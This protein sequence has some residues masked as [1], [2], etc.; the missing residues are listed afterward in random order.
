MKNKIL[1]ILILFSLLFIA[2]ISFSLQIHLKDKI[3]TD[4]ENIFLK[5]IA[6]IVAE[7]EV[8][9]EKY[10]DIYICRITQKTTILT[11]EEV[12]KVLQEKMMCDY[13]IVGDKTVI[14]SSQYRITK[15]MIQ[16]KIIG[17]FAEKYSLS[18]FKLKFTFISE[19]NEVKTKDGD[20][21]FSTYFKK[22]GSIFGVNWCVIKVFLNNN[23]I[24]SSKIN[25]LVQR[26]FKIAYTKRKIEVGEQISQDDFYIKET[27]IE[28][29]PESY[30]L[31]IQT[32]KYKTLKNSID[33]D[34]PLLK[35]D[36]TD[37]YVV[38]K[39]TEVEI[40]IDKHGIKLTD[41]GIAI[42]DGK[43]NDIIKIKRINTNEIISV[44][45]VDFNKVKL[46]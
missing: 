14:E 12:D 30:F 17:D 33:V 27:L 44:K 29:T 3:K 28:E 24:L 21:T 26:Y 2:N 6:E 7:I 13:I 8:N 18:G 41:R 10:S 4:K 31:D 25:F 34:A 32:L 37:L 38:K 46:E 5:D 19:I 16:D 40:I 39:N 42:E 45:V 9:T 15:K 1:G 36:I 20:I 11:S 22:D 23:C 43:Y 35:K